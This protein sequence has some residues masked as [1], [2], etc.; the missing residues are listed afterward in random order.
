MII[1]KLQNLEVSRITKILKIDQILSLL[2]KW[3]EI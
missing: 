3:E 2:E 1:K